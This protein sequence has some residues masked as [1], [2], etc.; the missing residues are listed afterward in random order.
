[1][2]GRRMSSRRRRKRTDVPTQAMQQRKLHIEVVG[3]QDAHAIH[4]VVLRILS[5]IGVVVE[6]EV[7]RRMLLGRADCREAADGYV[8]ISQDLVE[9]ALETVPNKVLLYDREGNQVVDTS[10]SVPSFCVGHNC[11]N[12]LDYESGEHRSGTLRDIVHTAKV[13]E[14]LSYVDVVA[15]LGYPTD[16]P[17]SKEAELSVTALIDHTKKPV[18]FTG[19]D[20][21]EADAIWSCLAGAVGG[22]E[23]LA[24]KPCGLDLTGPV[25][26]LK[27]GDEFC[28]RVTMAADRSL[29]LVCFPAL[30]P[31]MSGP[32]SLAGA[33]AQ[34]SA[35]SL[36]GVVIHQLTNP[37]APIMAGSS[38]L[39]MDMRRADLA[40]GSPELMLAGIGAVD[41]FNAIGLPS[42]VGAGCSD[43][44]V[45]DLQAAS[46]VGAN[47]ALAALAKTG[48][49]HRLGFLS[50]G[51]TGSLE[52]LVLCDELASMTNS[53]AGGITVDDENLAFDAIKRSAHDNGFI[54]DPHTIERYQTE[55][56]LPGMFDRSDVARWREEGGANM[57]EK[58]KD[59]LRDLLR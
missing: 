17:V 12:V 54:T 40:Y 52:M 59:R 7:A 20:E 57:G 48:F 10:S 9:R 33:I 22:W 4:S 56:W 31:G 16:V 27:L 18:A 26:P 30:F 2:I 55:M 3:R 51:R 34:S 53:F 21:V 5:E 39:P 41:Y 46:E 50:G 43:S 37:G 1:M 19:H 23:N 32:I 58:I 25:S 28:R 13:T 11:V 36:A 38:I 35:E 14:Q 24:D 45:P 49:I 42:W 44:H 47:M 15:S 6:D 8:Q 29:P